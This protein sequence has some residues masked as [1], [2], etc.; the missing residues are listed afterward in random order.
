MAIFNA[1]FLLTKS[2]S[3]FQFAE[4]Y[5]VYTLAFVKTRERAFFFFTKLAF[6]TFIAYT[7][8]CILIAVPVVVAIILTLFFAA[9][10]AVI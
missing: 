5:A 8:H 9:V 3:P 10:F 2:S 7:L 6:E 4:T 1:G